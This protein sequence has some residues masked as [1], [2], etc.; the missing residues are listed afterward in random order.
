[1]KAKKLFISILL[2]FVSFPSLY[3][4]NK[5]WGTEIE[6]NVGKG[7]RAQIPTVT[8]GVDIVEGFSFNNGLSLGGGIGAVYANGLL[9]EIHKNMS[10]GS[11]VDLMENTIT[12]ISWGAKAFVRSKYV[13][14]SLPGCPFVACDAGYSCRIGDKGSARMNTGFF[15]SPGIGGSMVLFGKKVYGIISYD[16]FQWSYEYLKT[17]HKDSDPFDQRTVWS[18][19]LRIHIGLAL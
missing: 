18:N 9:Q 16:A 1:M 15:V 11:S 13:I 17:P 12:D 7:L 14:N 19:A 6:F 10:D 4:Q 8:C 2:L 5:G 3:S